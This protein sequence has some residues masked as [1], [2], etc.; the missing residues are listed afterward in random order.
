M[1]IT[2]ENTGFDLNVGIFMTENQHR[3]GTNN[4][5]SQVDSQLIRDYLMI[6]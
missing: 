2:L 6:F 1:T 4:F 3:W 5:D